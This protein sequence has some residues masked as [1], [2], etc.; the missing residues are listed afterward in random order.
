M[1]TSL[2][3]GSN[4]IQMVCGTVKNNKLVL[5]AFETAIL[6]DDAIVNGIITNAGAFVDGME[7]LITAYPGSNMEKVRISIGLSPAFAK[8]RQVPKF[9]E[10]Q[11]LEWMRGEFE[12]LDDPENPLVYDYAILASSK[13]EGDKALLCA[14]SEST[15]EEYIKIFDELDISISCIDIG[16]S[17]QIKFIHKMP[18]TENKNILV[19]CLDGNNLEAALYVDGVFNT[20]NRTR[21]LSA[22]GSQEL[23]TEVDDVISKFIQFNKGENNEPIDFLYFGGFGQ[24]QELVKERTAEDYPIELRNISIDGMEL[25]EGK[26]GGFDLG[27]YLYAVGNLF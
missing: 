9:K 4:K 19:L 5:E 27:E 26:S 15:I 25:I 12:E 24:E 14:I 10:A 11:M 13:T 2:Y 17:S 20:S 21:L 22:R 3:I 6:S 23:G 16:R 8:V 1:E 7:K 18:S